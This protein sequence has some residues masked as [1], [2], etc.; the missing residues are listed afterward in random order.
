MCCANVR[1]IVVTG[2]W[3]VSSITDWRWASWLVIRGTLDSIWEWF[4]SSCIFTSCTQSLSSSQM[5]SA[6]PQSHSASS[7]DFSTAFPQPRLS[8]LSNSTP[9]QAESSPSL[10]SFP[11]LEYYWLQTVFSD[12]T[13][14]TVCIQM[15]KY[16]IYKNTVCDCT[17]KVTCNKVYRCWSVLS[18]GRGR[19][20]CWYRNRRDECCP[21]TWKCWGIW[22]HGGG[23]SSHA[24]RISPVP[25]VPTNR[26]FYLM[27]V[28]SLAWTQ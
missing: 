12:Y 6:A 23:S 7:Q 14:H 2:G 10:L 5:A 24:C 16:L 9:T 1:F 13:S 4:T 11:K 28:Y 20:L 21:L 19:G 3:W 17:V 26:V 22:G 8:T 18:H 15:P 27:T 25:S